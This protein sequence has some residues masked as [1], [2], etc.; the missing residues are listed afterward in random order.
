M[1]NPCVVVPHYRHEQA[2][3]AVIGRLKTHNLRCYLVDDGS[4]PQS[5]PMLAALAA[6]ESA[7]LRVLKLPDNR[8]KG[9]AVM[10]GCAAAFADGH[11]HAV[12]LDA[13]GQHC[14]EDLPR[15]IA[16]AQQ[17]PQSVIAGVA[18]YDDAVPRARLYG[19][20][21]THFWVWINTLS[22]GIRDS[23]CGFRVYPLAPALAVWR[24][25]R[26]GRRMDFDTEILVRMHWA[27]CAVE[28]LPTQVRYPLDG[29]SHFRLWHDNLRISGMHARL[30]FGMLRRA[31]RLL[32]RN[33][34]SHS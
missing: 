16:A 33:P 34:A 30:F 27:G 29:V 8:G 21:V 7:W 26:H 22:F 17:A 2:I 13:D 25:M 32:L 10:A 1:I 14:I 28:N 24:E 20:W 12:Q 5:A 4:G 3:A 31:P 15:F 11:T 6:A 19:R 18:V 23:M 9:V